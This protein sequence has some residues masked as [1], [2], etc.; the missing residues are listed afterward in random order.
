MAEMEKMDILTLCDKIALDPEVKARV[1]DFAAGF[2]FSGV[3]RY[4]RDFYQY[5]KMARALEGLQI[6]LGEDKDHIAVLACMLRACAGA[7][8]VYREKGICDGIYFAT[9][10]CFTRFM[11]ET[12]KMTQRRYFDRE[13]WTPRQAG[14]HLFRIGELE[15]EKKPDGGGLVI[16]M[17]IP[18]DAGF[19]DAAVEKSLEA[20]RAFFARYYP[21]TEGAPYV[22][23]SWLLDSQLRAMLPESANIIKFQNRFDICGEGEQGDDF[24]QWVFQTRSTRY[25]DYP[26]DTTL[27]RNMKRH[28]L[29]GGAVRNAYG[30]LKR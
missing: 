30:R 9:M 11:E 7:Y 15:Y 26:E 14:C 24:A 20:A 28:L 27:R 2:D 21:E 10:K 25:E 16:S 19:S 23:H 1:L 3:E 22:C 13:W 12:Y 17:H 5:E 18:S 6:A 4:L 8:E 29:S